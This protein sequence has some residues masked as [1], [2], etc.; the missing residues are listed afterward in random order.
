MRHCVACHTEFTTDTRRCPDCGSR[1]LDARELKLWHI[2]QDELT[3]ESFVP[4]GV[5]EGPV[6]AGFVEQVFADNDIPHIVRSYGD[7]GFGSIWQPQTGWGVL[8][9]LDDDRGRAK[10]LLQQIRD[11]ATEPPE[12]GVA[13]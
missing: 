1:T 2:A 10:S 8:L 9:V 4:A 3:Q 6:E 11:A 12:D 13:E 7:D 5:L